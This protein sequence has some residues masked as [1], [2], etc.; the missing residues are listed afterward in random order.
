M[1]VVCVL[2]NSAVYGPQDVAALRQGIDA[3][4]GPDRLLCLS[5]VDVPCARIPLSHGWPGW[6]AKMELFRP[7]LPGDLLYFDLDTVIVGNLSDIAKVNRLTVLSDFNDQKNMASGM[8]YLP[9]FVRI[10]IWN[11]WIA[12]P[13]QHIN[14]HRSGGDQFFLRRFWNEKAD[15][16][17]T[18]VPGQVVSWKVHVQPSGHIPDDARV[19]CFHGWPKPKDLREPDLERIREHQ[20]CLAY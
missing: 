10:D 13:Q 3:Y 17:Q 12:N 2:Q 15:R 6:W 5:D 18:M 8:M 11:V 16:W 7:D 20:G 1:N 9:E 4:L 14:D 19:I